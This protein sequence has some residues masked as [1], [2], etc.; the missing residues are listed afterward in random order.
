MSGKSETATWVLVGGGMLA[1][2][3]LAAGGVAVWMHLGKEKKVHKKKKEDDGG[4]TIVSYVPSEPGDR[5]ALNNQ[6]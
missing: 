4:K 2:F 5:S 1:G 6:S 3:V